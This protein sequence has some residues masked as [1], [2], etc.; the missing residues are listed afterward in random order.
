MYPVSG[1]FLQAVQENTRKYYWT[2][3]ITTKNGAEYSF[4]AEDIVK[5][6]GYIS[7]QCCGSTEIELGTVY[8][9]EMGITLFSAIDRYSLEGARVELTYHLRVSRDRDLAAFISGENTTDDSGKVGNYAWTV[10]DPDVGQTICRTRRKN[11]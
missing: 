9:S 10:E 8:S 7:S 5:G 3:K 4:V 11:G 6:S 1:A 2:G